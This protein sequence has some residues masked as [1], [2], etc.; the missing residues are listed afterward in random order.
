MSTEHARRVSTAVTARGLFDYQDMFALGAA[1]L[2]AASI[3][4]CPAGASPFGA[5]VRARGGR[6]LSVDPAYHQPAEDVL[7]Q[8]AA[9]LE[10]RDWLA[11][12]A[13]GI[14]WTYLGSPDAHIRA[15][16]VAADLFA[17]DYRSHPE[18]Y[19][20]A[21][22]PDLPFADDC[23]DL[24]LSG[25]LLFAYD[26]ALSI[27]QHVAALL[28][29]VRVTRGEVRVHPVHALHEAG[30]A[31]YAHLDHVRDVLDDHGIVT[32]LRPIS[33]SWIVGAR[34]MLVCAPTR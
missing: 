20:A 10:R 22:L 9:N 28:E 16:Q 23:F 34:Q 24:A 3:L 32:E 11:A 14:D 6:V 29:L 15:S 12:H 18:H 30:P 17:V 25:H 31:R 5:Q 21:A 1:E 26:Q 4:D 8:V 33:K 7:A 13:E 19:A 27:D 2:A